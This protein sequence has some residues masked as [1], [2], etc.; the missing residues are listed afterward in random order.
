VTTQEPS[1]GKVMRSSTRSP[2]DA[3][4]ATRAH[5]RFLF[6]LSGLFALANVIALVGAA[7][8]PRGPRSRAYSLSPRRWQLRWAAQSAPSQQAVE[9]AANQ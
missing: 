8:S 4:D 6:A 2:N 3:K 9:N 5:A 1:T 7:A